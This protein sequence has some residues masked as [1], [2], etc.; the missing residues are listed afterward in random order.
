[1]SDNYKPNVYDAVHDSICDLYKM[2]TE[3]GHTDGRFFTDSTRQTVIE[4]M[5]EE[6]MERHNPA[7]PSQED[8]LTNGHRGFANYTDLELAWECQQTIAGWCGQDQDDNADAIF[9]FNIVYKEVA[10]EIDMTLNNAVEN[11]ILK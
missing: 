10:H 7:L 8:L 5:V 11:S 9:P 4:Y 6:M 1:M 2:K 3:L